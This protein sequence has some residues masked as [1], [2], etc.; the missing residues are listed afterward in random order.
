[1]F[2]HDVAR[3]LLKHRTIVARLWVPWPWRTSRESLGFAPRRS[4]VAGRRSPNGQDSLSGSPLLLLREGLRRTTG[5]ESAPE[6]ERA[7][8]AGAAGGRPAT[9]GGR[10]EGSKRGH[11]RNTAGGCDMGR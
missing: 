2:T 4:P 10:W 8:G 1:W 6:E 3:D 7:D 9:G 11:Q 5:R